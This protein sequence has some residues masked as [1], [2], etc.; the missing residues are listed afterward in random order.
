MKSLDLEYFLSQPITQGLLSAVR[1]IGEFKGKQELF[2]EQSP[3]ILETLRKTAIIQSVESSNRI[4][5]IT[6]PHERIIELVRN[7]TIPANR[8]EQEIAGYRDVLSAIHANYS[9][10]QFT[11][12]LVLQF[13]RDMYK[14]AADSGGLYGRWK[15]AD[16][17]IIER[18][19]DGSRFVRFDPVPAFQTAEYMEQ[20]H[21][22][23]EEL[24]SSGEIEPL[25]LIA[26]YVLDFLCIHPFGDGN[27]RIARLLTLLLLYKADYEVGRYISLEMQVENTR[28][29]YYDTLY[30]SSQGWHEGKHNI[31]PWW[32]YFLGVMLMP[33]YKE[34]ERRA[35]FI[36]N[37][38]GAK[39]AMIFD[40]LNNIS[41][42]FST[43]DLQ[44]RC[45]NVSIDMIRK[46][47]KDGRK[48]GT[49]ECLGRGPDTKWRIRK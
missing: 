34:F 41:G 6:A 38:R 10:M 13:H 28:E 16:N 32:E 44:E 3:Q 25:L 36:I 4:E 5:G 27:G 7:K 12:G 11:T 43:K 40:C 18:R 29:S 26:A 31:L 48:A 42:E 33:A 21:S 22:K 23:F 24:R 1:M 37:A 49:L 46:I 14:Y 45:P 35:G 15:S 19:P 20:L 2:K 39:T 30:K 17:E 9:D 8:N 47:L